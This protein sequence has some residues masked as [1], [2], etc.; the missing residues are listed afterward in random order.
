M[1]NTK[2]YHNKFFKTKGEALFFQKEHGGALYCFAPKSR[3][4]NDF[5]AEMA[6]ALDARKEVVDPLKTPF[7]VAWNEEV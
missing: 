7:C 2:T 5:L 4:K 1:P 6:V 3:S